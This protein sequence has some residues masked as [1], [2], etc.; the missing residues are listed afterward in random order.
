MARDAGDLV[1]RWV[2]PNTMGSTLRYRTQPLWRKWR[3]RSASFMLPRFRKPHARRGAKVPFPQARAGTAR[4]VLAR[5]PDSLWP[6]PW[7]RLAK[8]RR[9]TLPQNKYSRP[10]WQ[11]HKRL[12]ISFFLIF[13]AA[14]GRLGHP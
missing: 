2:E 13:T 5:P 14:H 4:P 10:L 8:S 9:E 11:V 7:F 3:S 12:S 1:Q 6:L